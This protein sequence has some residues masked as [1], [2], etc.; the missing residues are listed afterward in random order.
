MSAESLQWLNA[1]VLIGYTDKRGHAWHY[2]ASAQGAEPN[3]Y[4]GPI[5]VEDVRRRLFYW[6]A[7]EAQVTATVTDEDGVLSIVDPSRKA[8]VRPDTGTILGVF[9]EGYKPHQFDEWLLDSVA[10]LLDDELQIGSAGL[11]RGGAVAWVTIEVPEN[12][13]TPE[14]VAFRPHLNAATSHDGT[15]ATTFNR[16]ISLPVCDNTLAAAL[17]DPH[18]RL[19]VKHSR[20][21]VLKLQDAKTALEL[22][23][24]TADD[25]SQQIAA[26]CAVKVSDRE[27]A[28]CLDGLV[29]VPEQ[30]GRGKTLAEGKR[31]VLQ[32][33]WD[34]DSRVSPWRNTAF[35]VVQA[36]NTAWHHEW[37]ARGNRVERNLLCALDGSV[38]KFD[39][40]TLATL[41]K[42]LDEPVLVAA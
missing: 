40:A 30:D 2:L 11:L 32:R 7:K 28:K 34:H 5:P 23:Y 3:H 10:T 21:S 4:P 29:P 17:A 25:F 36:A 38:D 42:V 19:K 8:I 16:S 14:G 35:G 24:Q 12:V 1:N 33:L 6:R 15:L 13:V 37:H 41:A 39:Y 20:Y 22:V 18:A 9:K 31:E 27:W 26:L